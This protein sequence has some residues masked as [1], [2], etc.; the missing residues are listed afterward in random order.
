VE[1]PFDLQYVPIMN[2]KVR[3]IIFVLTDLTMPA[4]VAFPGNDPFL[5]LKL[6]GLIGE[7]Y[8]CGF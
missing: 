1:V 7:F 3:E 4:G 2:R 8:V 5:V 6:R